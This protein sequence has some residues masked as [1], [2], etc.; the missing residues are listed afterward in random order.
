MAEHDGAAVV[1]VQTADGL[2]IAVEGASV[3]AAAVADGRPDTESASI[4]VEVAV[5]LQHILVDHDI[6][7]QLA[8]FQTLDDLQRVT[9]AAQRT[10]NIETGGIDIQS[11]H[12]FGEHD[13]IVGKCGCFGCIDV[14]HGVSF[15]EHGF[16]RSA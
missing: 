5:V 6:S 10:V 7:G 16:S 9:A 2:A 11:V 1:E 3:L 15:S 8:V 4:A 12:T 14:G 13:G